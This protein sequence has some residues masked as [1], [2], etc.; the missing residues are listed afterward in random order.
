MSP[1]SQQHAIRLGYVVI[2]SNKLDQ[3]KVFGADAFGLHVDALPDGS[4]AFRLDEYQKRLIVQPGPAEDV[5]SLGWEVAD[6]TALSL[7]LERVRAEG[8]EVAASDP[9][10]AERRGVEGFSAFKGPKGL[11]MELFTRPKLTNQPLAAKVDRFVTGQGGLGHVA[12]VTR[13]PEQ[14]IAQLSRV[15]G[16]KLSDTITDK[17]SGAEMEFSFLHLNPRHHSLAIA[18]TK[19]L[20][21]DPIRTRIQHLAL[22]A[23]RLED[24]VDAYERTKALGFRITMSMGQHPN[25]EEISF[26]ATSPSGFEMELGWNAK[27]IAL[28]EPWE[29]QAYRGISRWGHRPERAP[30]ISETLGQ[31][32]TAL[33]SLFRPHP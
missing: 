20:R 27:T 15:L 3:W 2:E 8:L 7:A 22:E 19:G 30:P 18:A 16:A 13:F 5:V 11:S 24:V 28:D 26:Y 9:T 17:L 33:S 31:L 25:D 14:V 29:P 1:A 21:L 23:A 10:A 4:L 6:D 32:G 12:L